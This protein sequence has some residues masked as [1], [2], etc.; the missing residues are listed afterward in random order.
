MGGSKAGPTQS[1][2]VN[3][4]PA[5]QARLKQVW[6]ATQAEAGNA[7]PGVDPSVLQALQGF[8]GYGTAGNLG[9]G[10]L[11]G[12]QAAY[13]QMANPYQ[14]NVLDA[15]KNNWQWLQSQ[16]TNNI[17][18]QATQGGY[19]GGSRQGVA[20]G[21]A[22][23]DLARQMADQMAQLQLGGYN[24]VMSQAQGLAGMGLAGNQQAAT[25][26]DYLRNVHMAQ[27]PTQHAYDIYNQA[28]RGL[29]YGQ[30]NTSTSS[31]PWGSVIGGGLLGLGGAALAGGLI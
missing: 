11:T 3:M 16:V 8:Q 28:I 7:V 21:E 23:S 20:Q 24:Q 31:T 25:L 1:S 18:D 22:Q 29:P 14:S 19:F 10:A 2:S 27:D 30:T 26:G 17:N 15:M 12:D 13:N 9:L 6:A 4:D 5:T